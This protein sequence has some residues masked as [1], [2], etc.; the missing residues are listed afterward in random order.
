MELMIVF[1]CTDI[2]GL[3]KIDKSRHCVGVVN[4]VLKCLDASYEKNHRLSTDW[5]CTLLQCP[6]LQFRLSLPSHTTSVT[7]FFK[8]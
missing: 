3:D 5:H 1:T 2:A 7:P 4:A 8:A 6:P